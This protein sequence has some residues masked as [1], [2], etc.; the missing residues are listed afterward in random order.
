MLNL[1]GMYLSLSLSLSANPSLPPLV[2]PSHPPHPHTEGS[3][4]CLV[5]PLPARPSLSGFSEGFSVW[6]GQELMRYEV[7]GITLSSLPAS[8][9]PRPSAATA[10]LSQLE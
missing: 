5:M 8:L 9:L 10:S 3:L 6:L 4:I 7:R 1:V 2:C